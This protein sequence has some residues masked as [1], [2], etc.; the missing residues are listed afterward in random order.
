MFIIINVQVKN[1]NN[2][3]IISFKMQNLSKANFIYKYNN[4]VN[5]FFFY[6]FYSNVFKIQRYHE[7]NHRP[8]NY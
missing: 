6:S 3:S 8:S 4:L 5:D 1:T 7:L 2:A